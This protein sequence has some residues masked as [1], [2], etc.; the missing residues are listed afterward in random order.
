M[1]R[2]ML[3]RQLL[4]AKQEIRELRAIADGLRQNSQTYAAQL[5]Q[6]LHDIDVLNDDAGMNYQLGSVPSYV[7]RINGLTVLDHK[8][9]RIRKLEEILKTNGIEIPSQVY[10]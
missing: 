5:R 6:A 10:Y 1:T 2:E 7:R 8:K 3:E 4:E 9:I